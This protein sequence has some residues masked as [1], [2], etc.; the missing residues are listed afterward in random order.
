M[1]PRR[2][3]RGPAAAA[4]SSSRSRRSV[5][6]SASERSARWRR[7]A[8]AFSSTWARLSDSSRSSSRSRAAS[9]RTCARVPR[10][11]RGVP[12]PGLGVGD[13]GGMLC[14]DLVQLGRVRTG[15]GLCFSEAGGELLSLPL[16]AGTQPF[17]LGGGAGAQ[18]LKGRSPGGTRPL[19]LRGARGVPVS[20]RLGALLATAGG[21]FSIPARLLAG[22][23]GSRSVPEP[24]K[25]LCDPVCLRTAGALLE[26]RHF[27]GQ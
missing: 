6:A 19:G 26:A 12:G 17:Q 8:R 5:P 9:A 18:L 14:P 22:R 7:S 10:L 21:T 3:R 4:R 15:L 25:M 27:R 11:G 1:P 2:L 16:G 20:L 24:A 13:G 23:A